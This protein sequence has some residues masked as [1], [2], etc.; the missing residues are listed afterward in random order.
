ML[1]FSLIWIFVDKIKS[2]IKIPYSSKL[3]VI[4][5]GNINLGG[6]G[7]TPVAIFLFNTLMDMGHK[8]IFLTSGYRGKVR[9]P[10]LVND[11][12]SLFGDE[13]ILLKNAGPTVVSKNKLKGIKFIEALNLNKTLHDIIIMDDG[14]QNYTIKKTLSFLTVDR[15]YLFGNNF[16]FPSGPLRQPYSA[17]KNNID[18]VIMTGD[19]SS[20]KY[21]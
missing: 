18:F 20:K 8:P 3:K 21:S 1:P 15:H 2:I 13:A 16:C 7:K 9:N 12:V 10:T 19:V 6:T 5:I 14:L 17:C 11:D 4:C